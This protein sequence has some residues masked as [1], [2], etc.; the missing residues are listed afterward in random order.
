[1]DSINK[2]SFHLTRTEMKVIKKEDH[3]PLI[4]EH[5]KMQV[6]KNDH[7]YIYNFLVYPLFTIIRISLKLSNRKINKNFDSINVN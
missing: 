6:G 5:L 7:L 1:M 2:E 4:K 3:K